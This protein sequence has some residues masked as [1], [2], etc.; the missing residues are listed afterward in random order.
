MNN[1]RLRYFMS[2]SF[3]DKCLA[4]LYFI[5]LVPCSIKMFMGINARIGLS[6]LNPI[7]EISLLI[8]LTVLSFRSF[9]RE[10]KWWDIAVVVSIGWFVL[11]SPHI[12]P[13]TSI[14]VVEFSPY[15]LMYC[16]PYYLVGASINTSKYEDMF[17]FVGYYGLLVN[18]FICLLAVLGMAQKLFGEGNN[19]ELAYGV[20][21]SLILV[22]RQFSQKKSNANMLLVAIGILLIFALGSR[23]ALLSL[24]AFMAG[25]LILF[26]EYQ[27]PLLSHSHQEYD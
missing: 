16:L 15:F 5:A 3:S 26:R 21:P 20:L 17:D 23:G 7:L 19:M 1:N 18:I 25:Y 11:W 4:L 10:L 13:Q 14:A 8:T 27:N 9:K 12:Y 6:T 2:L 22:T 24:V